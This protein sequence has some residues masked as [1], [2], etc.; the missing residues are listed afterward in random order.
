MTN[1]Q[2]YS[3]KTKRNAK[4]RK[5]E[6]LLKIANG[7]AE[8]RGGKLLTT[9]IP[10]TN[11]YLHWKCEYSFHQ[12][13][14]ASYTKVVHSKTWCPQCAVFNHNGLSNLLEIAEKRGGKLLST[15]Y[16]GTGSKYTK[17]SSNGK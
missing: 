7:T 12:I 6:K 2:E 1:E 8:Q 3:R 9:S 14:K 17:D 13:W 16:T 5:Q 4:R 10:D 11:A 15:V